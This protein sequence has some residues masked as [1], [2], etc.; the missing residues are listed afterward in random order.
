MNLLISL[1]AGILLIIMSFYVSTKVFKGSSYM[2]GGVFALIVA[3]V[4]SMLAAISWPGADVFAIHLALYLLTVYGMT[5]VTSQNRKKS[6]LH[7]A[8]VSLFLTPIRPG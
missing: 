1:P 8:P 4:Y 7:W 2:L 3:M 6:K 5:I